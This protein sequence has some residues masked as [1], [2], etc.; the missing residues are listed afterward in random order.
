MRGRMCAVIHRE[1]E[2]FGFM[3]EVDKSYREGTKLPSISILCF[4]LRRRIVAGVRDESWFVCVRET[5]CGDNGS[6]R[7]GSFYLFKGIRC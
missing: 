1:S 5:V 4:F 7:G 2:I 6:E 3:S